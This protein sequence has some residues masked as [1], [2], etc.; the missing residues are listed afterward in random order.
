MV[1]SHDTVATTYWLSYTLEALLALC[2][3]QKYTYVYTFAFRCEGPVTERGLRR[4]LAKE[5]VALQTLRA[6][7]IRSVTLEATRGN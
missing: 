7:V 6:Y 3:R 4:E 2:K 1:P 5:K